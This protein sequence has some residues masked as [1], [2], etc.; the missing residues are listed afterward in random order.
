MIQVKKISAE[1]VHGRMPN[2]EKIQQNLVDQIRAARCHNIDDVDERVT[3]TDLR[4]KNEYRPWIDTFYKEIDPFMN[5]FAK[6]YMH[7]NYRISNCWF[8]RYMK[9]DFSDWHTHS[10]CMWANVYFL[11]LPSPEMKTSFLNFGDRTFVPIPDI[12]E[13]DII[14]FPSTLIHCSKPNP[15]DDDKIVIA[16]NSDFEYSEVHTHIRARSLSPLSSTGQT[17]TSP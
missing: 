17:W 12:K 6:Q 4:L 13:G 9:G 10:N 8:M 14:S 2:H 1:Y 7:V 5:A 16:F 3:F 11:K 15:F